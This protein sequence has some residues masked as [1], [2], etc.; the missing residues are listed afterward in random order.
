MGSKKQ[1]GPRRTPKPAPPAGPATEARAAVADEPKRS[2]FGYDDVPTSRELMQVIAACPAV[3]T[4]W[5]D[6]PAF[7]DQMQNWRDDLAEA[8]RRSCAAANDATGLMCELID[9]TRKLD[10]DASRMIATVT[11]I[12]A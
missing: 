3:P 8:A 2:T 6:L 1:A 11:A 7:M 12:R 4:H 10:E 5:G 9:G